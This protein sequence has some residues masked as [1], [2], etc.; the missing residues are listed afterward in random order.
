MSLLGMFK[1]EFIDIIEW[2]DQDPQ[3]LVWKFPRY[4]DEIK[5]NTKL[6]VR[7]GQQAVF[8]NEG[9]I[10]DVFQPGMYTLQTENMPIMTTL[11]G[12]KY[13]F[14]SPFNQRSCKW[15]YYY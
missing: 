3:T 12:W 7:E 4:Q 5:M 15:Q 11:K 1:N 13:G 2:A 14:N 9:K 10:A 8:I 6:T